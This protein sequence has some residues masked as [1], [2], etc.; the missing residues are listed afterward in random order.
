[1]SFR[2]RGSPPLLSGR[3]RAIYRRYLFSRYG[4][5]YDF[6]DLDEDDPS[7]ESDRDFAQ[8]MFDLELAI[9]RE[10]GY[11]V[12]GNT[13]R[14]LF[15]G[16]EDRYNRFVDFCQDIWLSA[17]P[18]QAL[19]EVIVFYGDERKRESKGKGRGKAVRAGYGAVSCSGVLHGSVP[20]RRVASR[21]LRSCGR[22]SS[23]TMLAR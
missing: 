23:R 21:A 1:M 9:K 20:H 7:Y 16:P 19:Q 22:R 10:Y 3:A 6:S 17:S 4:I 11:T 15:D 5:G 13:A 8:W 18:E 14:Y 12:G 2:H